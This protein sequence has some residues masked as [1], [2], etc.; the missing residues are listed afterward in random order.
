MIILSRSILR[1]SVTVSLFFLYTNIA[2]EDLPRRY[3]M[4]VVGVRMQKMNK[5]KIFFS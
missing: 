4:Q 5:N 2:C 1:K 3:S